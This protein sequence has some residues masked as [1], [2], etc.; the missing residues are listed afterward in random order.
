MMD[1]NRCKVAIVDDRENKGL[2]FLVAARAELEAAGAEVHYYEFEG[3]L[4]EEIIDL[5]EFYDYVV[6]AP[7]YLER[8]PNKK[9]IGG[10]YTY[11]L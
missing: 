8:V 10:L 3:E 7:E 5:C 9:R 11:D 1:L 4:K 6:P 2:K